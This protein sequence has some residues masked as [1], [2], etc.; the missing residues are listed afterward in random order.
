MFSYG[1]NMDLIDQKRACKSC[2]NDK[3]IYNNLK[4]YGEMSEC[5]YCQQRR[6]TISVKEIAEEVEGGITTEYKQCEMEYYDPV[7][8]KYT[9]ST[10]CLEDILYGVYLCRED[11]FEDICS[12]I[13]IDGWFER[14]NE[15]IGD[16]E[17]IS[18]IHNNKWKTF[19]H[20]VKYETRYVFFNQWDEDQ[21]DERAKNIL[22][23]IS[24]AVEKLDLIKQIS[25]Q[26]GFYRGRTHHTR[27][28]AFSSD[29][30]LASPPARYAKANR[31]SAEGISIFYGANNI[32]TVLAEIYN[33]TDRYA[34]IA[35]FKN[36]NELCLLDL[37][38]VLHMKLPSLFDRK[39]RDKRGYIRFFKDFINMIISPVD[40]IPAIEYVPTQ[41]L[42]EYF[43]HVYGYG[44]MFDGI[45]YPSAK[46]P[47]GKCYALFFN[48]EQ[49]IKGKDQRLIMDQKTI[50]TYRL[51]NNI[52]YEEV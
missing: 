30:Q 45:L 28:G 22:E 6:K 33:G 8:G 4:K 44:C 52:Q 15:Y 31:M 7:K 38:N 26:M 49:C 20:M 21:E 3:Y 50:K 18:A 36:N 9:V 48:N 5:S 40:N 51:F 19:C 11:L 42:T 27:E 46:N 35:Q 37:S 32:K 43:R 41:I 16:K 25:P 34:T 39:N 47:R 24:K 23:F 14:D 13:A 17:D 2:I 1:V 29:N 12:Y 10:L